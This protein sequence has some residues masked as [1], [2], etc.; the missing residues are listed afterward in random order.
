MI[1]LLVT[2]GKKTQDAPALDSESLTNI[3]YSPQNFVLPIPDSI[4]FPKMSIPVDN[5]LAVEG[6]E[7]GRRLFYDPILS[8]DSG[9]ACAS[10]H[11]QKFAFSS[12]TALSRGVDSLD[13]VRNAMSL[14]NVGFVNKGLFWD[15]RAATLEDQG[16]QPVEDV[17]EMHALWPNIEIKLQRSADYPARFRKAF[18][19]SKK[20]EITKTLAIKAVAQFE[21]TILSTNAKIDRIARRL[22]D[23]TDEEYEGYGL[24]TSISSFPD[25]QCLHCHNSPFY[26]ANNYFNNGLDS[27]ASL[28]DF[29]DKGR[30]AFTVNQ[31][32]NGKFRA[33]TLRNIE[34]TAPYMHDGRFKTLD[35]VLDHYASGGH[36]SENED[37]FLPQIKSIQLTAKQKKS[38]IAFLKTLT[39][40]TFVQNPALSNP[41]H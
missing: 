2:C 6:V 8:R 28:N 38:I 23:F 27:A 35:E 16:L 25:A 21:R 36:Y 7:L 10:C 15:G 4:S 20:S 3:P 5:P 14:T 30:G 33:P 37:P 18:G 32:D 9:M 24:F 19:I 29:K 31:N 40:T 12:P 17:R 26:T 11:Q 22:T 34:L 1:S 41:F 39:D 13:G